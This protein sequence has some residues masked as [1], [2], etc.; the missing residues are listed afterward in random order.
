MAR[1]RAFDHL[2]AHKFHLVDVSVSEGGTPIPAFNPVLGFSSITMPE[3]TAEV[4]TF[5]EGNNEFPRKVVKGGT[6]GTITL[7][8][9]SLFF[10]NDFWNWIISSIKGD[11]ALSRRRTL[12]LVQLANIDA[13]STPGIIIGTGLAT[14][15]G[16]EIGTRPEFNLASTAAVSGGLIGIG[17][18]LQLVPVKT[19]ILQKCIAT[20][21]KPG[22]DFD[23]T[24]GAVSIQELDIECEFFEQFALGL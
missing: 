5:M 6:V 13:L 11:G 10:D 23:A 15:V 12:V 9:G 14:A 19:W 7:Q 24:S 1:P 3:M 8:R 20:R 22:T 17:A 18:A 4:E 16:T 2:Q 21:F